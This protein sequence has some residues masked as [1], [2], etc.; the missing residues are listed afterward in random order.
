MTSRSKWTP[1]ILTS[2]RF[3][4]SLQNLKINLESLEVVEVS[5][6]SF[7]IGNEVGLNN[8]QNDLKLF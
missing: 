5:L 3:E 6:N 4:V 2:K 7:K 1:S 8:L